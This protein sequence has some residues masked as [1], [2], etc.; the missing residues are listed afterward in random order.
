MLNNK[1]LSIHRFTQISSI[2]ETVHFDGHCMDNGTNFMVLGRLW[3]HFLRH[4]YGQQS[5][6]SHNIYDVCDEE[7]SFEIFEKEVRL[8]ILQ[9]LN[10]QTE[11]I[12]FF[13]FADAVWIH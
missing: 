5:S 10:S 9:N 11:L 1:Q 2:L 12:F 8:S 3:Y 6:G 7:K 4:R 13:N